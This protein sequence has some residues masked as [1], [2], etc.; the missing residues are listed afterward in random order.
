MLGR[1]E[2]ERL[3][4]AARAR[5]RERFDIKAFHDAVLGSGALPLP[6]LGRVVGSSGRGS[7]GR[8]R[9]ERIRDRGGARITRR[10]FR[11]R[12]GDR[13]MRDG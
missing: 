9:R 10:A 2:I 8:E 5:L 12:Y 7:R 3:R 1:L 6:I 4:A 13:G 11:T